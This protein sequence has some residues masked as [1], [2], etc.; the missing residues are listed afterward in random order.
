MSII[1]PELIIKSNLRQKREGIFSRVVYFTFYG[2]AAAW[3]PF[4]NLYL[5]KIGLTGLQ[6]G[7]LAGVS[8]MSSVLAQPLWGF[9]GD[10]WGRRRV[11]VLSLLLAFIFLPVFTLRTEFSFF[12]ILAIFYSL[13]SSQGAPLI[14]S[15]TLDFLERE[16]RSSFGHIR[17]WG[18]VGWSILA[19]LSGR[20][21]V[22]RDMR[23]IFLIASLFLFICMVFVM[24]TSKRSA[25][26]GRR[27]FSRDALGPILKNR[28]LLLFFLLVMVVQIGKA[29]HGIF[30]PNY[31]NA[32]GGTT[33]HIG[34]AIA[35]QGVSE[36]PIYLSASAI[37]R[38]IGV[39]NTIILTIVVFAARSFLYSIVSTP[40]LALVLQVLHSSLALFIVATVE[41]VN[42]EVPS[43]WRATGQ[44]LLTAFYL[45]VGT[46]LGSLVWGYLY[47]LV[48][49]Q[50][51]Y[52]YS[53][54]VI[55]AVAIISIFALRHNRR[56]GRAM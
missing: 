1:E 23:L 13:V 8:R 20:L 51:M 39:I 38:R 33:Q 3:R 45:G 41:Y 16:K 12:F 27:G 18:A 31:I 5:E 28:N 49:V 9:L 21:I 6:I 15:L 17:L 36:L 10:L 19:F 53:S 43:E 42:R 26:L 14:D 47:D 11:L 40:S 25:G 29:P 46:F 34:L 54:L 35:I 48:G 4:F 56:A 24:G 44:S 37:M 30:F 52:F 7:A 55:S 22:D 2:A 50:Q 32:I